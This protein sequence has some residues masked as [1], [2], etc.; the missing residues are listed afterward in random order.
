MGLIPG[1]KLNIIA[2][3]SHLANLDK[4]GAFNA[5]IDDFLAAVEEA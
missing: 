2:G 3:A 1:S 4:P 5:A